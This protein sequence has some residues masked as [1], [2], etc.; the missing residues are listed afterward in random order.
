MRALLIEDDYYFGR[1][2]VRDLEE[3][4]PAVRGAIDVI[5]TERE[6]R[7]LFDDPS[8]HLAYGFIVLDVMVHW[9]KR[10]SGSTPDQ[11]VQQE[12]YFRAGVRCLDRIRRRTDTQQIPVVIHSALE[13]E[14]LLQ[15]IQQKGIIFER[16]EI[17]P[18][19]GNPNSLV[20]ALK[21]LLPQT[22]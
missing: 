15:A 9:D 1:E 6:F 22:S 12:G 2:V 13:S 10:S 11:D 4:F 3:N 16:I 8:R 19:S 18:K 21:R 14:K 17:V 20:E 5:K 7:T